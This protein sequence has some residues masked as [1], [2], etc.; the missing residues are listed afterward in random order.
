MSTRN[1]S[2]RCLRSE[3]LTAAQLAGGDIRGEPPLINQ[4]I[5]LPTVT[6]KCTFKGTFMRWQGLN[7][8]GINFYLFWSG[9]FFQLVVICLF[10]LE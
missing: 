3:G 7:S 4:R 10:F 1:A 5:A 8:F 2:S 6:G 9:F